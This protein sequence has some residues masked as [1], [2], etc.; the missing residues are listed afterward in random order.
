MSSGELMWFQGHLLSRKEAM[1]VFGEAEG[2]M[3]L[4]VSG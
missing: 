1:L 4:S 2:Q 3:F